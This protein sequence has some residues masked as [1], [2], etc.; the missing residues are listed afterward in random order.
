MLGYIDQHFK[1]Y[2][3]YNMRI[4]DQFTFCIFVH[5]IIVQM[6][7]NRVYICLKIEAFLQFLMFVSI[8]FYSVTS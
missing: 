6:K 8:E 1:A 3:K 4:E 2:I 5:S 7:G